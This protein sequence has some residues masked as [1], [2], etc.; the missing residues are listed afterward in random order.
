[1]KVKTVGGLVGGGEGARGC[2]CIIPFLLIIIVRAKRPGR[3]G[4][5]LKTHFFVLIMSRGVLSS[6]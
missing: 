2:C 6:R 5:P 4:G 3:G 1:M